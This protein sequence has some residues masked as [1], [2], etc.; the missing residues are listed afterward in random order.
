MSLID[1]ASGRIK[2]A[3]GNLTGDPTLRRKGRREEQKGEAKEELQRAQDE[4]AEK[5]QEVSDLERRS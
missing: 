5:A 1:K 2:Q 4:A 3:V